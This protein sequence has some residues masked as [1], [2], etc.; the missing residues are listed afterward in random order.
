MLIEAKQYKA[1]INDPRGKTHLADNRLS[2][3]DFFHVTC[4]IDEGLRNKIQ[5]GEFIELDRLLPKKSKH[6]E[7]RMEIVSR[8]GATFF[9]PAESGSNK[10]N[11]IRRFEQAFRVYAAIY[12]AHNPQRSA[13]IWQYVHCI[14]TAA[15]AYQWENVATYDYTFRQLM[16]F[17]PGRSWAK[18]YTQDWNL[19]MREL[20]IRNPTSNFQGRSSGGVPGG[21]NNEHNRSQQSKSSNGFQ[22]SRKADYC[23]DFNKGVCSNKHCKWINKC[24]YCDSPD[25]GIHVCPKL[26]KKGKR[27]SSGDATSGSNSMTV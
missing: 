7:G 26:D 16:A 8:N 19:C 27:S 24:K 12:S 6:L 10:I 13:E 2:D 25:H 20:I 14:N 15:A 23:W 11:G 21:Y 4:H 1:A 18:T 9:I 22:R 3:D 5:N 17:N